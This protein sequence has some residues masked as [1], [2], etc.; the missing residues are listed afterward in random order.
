ME[1]RSLGRPEAKPGQRGGG[2]QG[3]SRLSLGSVGAEPG[4]LEAEPGQRGGGARAARGRA[5]AAWGEEP[6]WCGAE[7]NR[8]RRV[9]GSVEGLRRG[10][11]AGHDRVMPMLPAAAGLAP[12]P[13][14]LRY[15]LRVL[16][17]GS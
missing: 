15:R 3:G 2:A 10:Q 17:G 5:L 12:L 1:G 16:M 11:A 13:L 6:G 4:R 7:P 8:G 14:P 9:C